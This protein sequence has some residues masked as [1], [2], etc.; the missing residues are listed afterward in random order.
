[1]AANLDTLKKYGLADAAETK[2]TQ[3]TNT[4]ELK[5]ALLG[6]PS[7]TSPS[8]VATPA[9]SVADAPRSALEVLSARIAEQERV[10]AERAERERYA[11]ATDNELDTRWGKAKDLAGWAVSGGNRLV[12][13]AAS[14]LPA[15]RGNSAL[16]LVDNRARELYAKPVRTPEEEAYLDQVP[17]YLTNASSN[18]ATYKTYRQL[19]EESTTDLA[20][21]K[22]IREA[23]E[24]SDAAKRGNPLRRKE[25]SEDFDESF[26]SV[27]KY[28]ENAGKAFK[29]GD[30]VEGAV[31]G[32]IGIAKL[33]VAG[34]GD[35]VENPMATWQYIAEQAAQLGVG[36]VKKVGKGLLAA[37][38]V[39]YG[40]RIYEER[41]NEYIAEHGKPPSQEEAFEMLAWAASAS[42]AEHL[43]ESTILSKGFGKFFG[44]AGKET[45]EA[46]AKT[47]TKEAP[48]SLRRRAAEG[49]KDIVTSI[50]S[51]AATEGYQTAVEEDLARLRDVQSWR[52]IFEGTMIGGAAAGGITTTGKT[53]QATVAAKERLKKAWEGAGI[54]AAENLQEDTPEQKRLAEEALTTGD[55]SKLLDTEGRTTYNPV[56][57]ADVLSKRARNTDLTEEQRADARNQLTELVSA[58]AAE[59]TRLESV[60][61][62]Q[63]KLAPLNES[64]AMLKEFIDQHPTEPERQAAAAEEI[65]TL[66]AEKLKLQEHADTYQ[67]T[68]KRKVGDAK[69]RATAVTAIQNQ[70][71]AS[72]R[73]KP[74]AVA[75]LAQKA[76]EVEDSPE[77]AEAVTQLVDMA[78][79]DPE[80]LS[81]LDDRTLRSLASSPA[82]SEE[83]REY[84]ET[85][86]E[87][88]AHA[89]ALN[90]MEGVHDNIL[91]GRPGFR[92]L[93]EYQA[94][95]GAALAKGDVK[96]V[97][98]LLYDLREFY[99]NHQAKKKS[100]EEAE[101]RLGTRTKGTI[102]IKREE[103]GSYAL[104]GKRP[105]KDNAGRARNGGIEVHASPK[106]REATAQRLENMDAELKAIAATGK[107]IAA[108]QQLASQQT[109]VTQPVK[110]SSPPPAPPAE[111]LQSILDST[112][113]N[114]RPTPKPKKAAQSV[115]EASPPVAP[116]APASPEVTTDESPKQETE[117]VTEPT[118]E[119]DSLPT[120]EEEEV[121]NPSTTPIATEPKEPQPTSTAQDAARVQ[122]QPEPE[123]AD[124]PD[125]VD[126]VPSVPVEENQESSLADEV[127]NEEEALLEGEQQTAEAGEKQTPAELGAEEQSWVPD[128]SK[129]DPT[130]F[131]GT[132][133]EYRE[134]DLISRYF[135]VSKGKATDASPK[136]LVAVKN[137]LSWIIGKDGLHLDRLQSVLAD[138]PTAEDL[139]ALG[140]FRMFMR[141]WYKPLSANLQ[142]DS[143]PRFYHKDLVQFLV[144]NGIPDNLIVAIGY[145]AF[146]WLGENSGG[147][148]INDDGA[149]NAIQGR[150]SDE[151][152][153]P[154]EK[155]LLKFSGTRRNAVATA[156]GKRIVQATGLKLIPGAPE[157]YMV[158]LELDL[159]GHALGLLQQAGF[160]EGHV[161]YS[162]FLERDKK[163]GNLLDKEG[164]AALVAELAAKSREL[165]STKNMEAESADKYAAKAN[166]TPHEFVR[167]RRQ[168]GKPANEVIEIATAHRESSGFL[169]KLFGAQAGLVFPSDEP[170][171]FEQERIKRSNR[172]IP[173]SL[174]EAATAASNREW[175]L[176]PVMQK[177]R[178]AFAPGALAFL[179]GNR[180]L[181]Y[182]HKYL[183]D[184]RDAANDGNQRDI[185]NLSLF[186]KLYSEAGRVFHFIPKIWSQQRSGLRENIINPQSSKYHRFNVSMP[187]WVTTF[188]PRDAASQNVRL[189][190]LAVAQGLGIKIEKGL[191]EQSIASLDA[192]MVKPQVK[193]ALG[194][195]KKIEGL[196]DNTQLSEEDQTLVLRVV[197]D[198][199]DL[200]IGGED[201][202]SLEALVQYARFEQ[203]R[204]DGVEFT[205]DIML[206]VDGTN[207]GP[208]LAEI[209]LGTVNPVLGQMFGFFTKN[210]NYTSTNAYK[211]VAGNH[212]LY[213][214]VAAL[215]NQ[216]LKTFKG[217]AAQ[218]A[219]D[220]QVF[221][222]NLMDANDAV[223]GK[224][225]TLVKQPVTSLIF[226]SG[227]RKTMKAMA[228]DVVEAFYERLQAIANQEGLSEADRVIQLKEAVAVM[229][230]MIPETVET[231]KR[232]IRVDRLP[233][234]STIQAAMETGLTPQQSWAFEFQYT[235]TVGQAINFA[236]D[237]AFGDFLERR[238]KLNMAAE[239]IWRR[240]NT[241]FQHLYRERLETLMRNGQIPS[242]EIQ[243]PGKPKGTTVR[244]PLEELSDTEM[245]VIRQT[246][247]PMAA[248]VHTPWSAH[249]ANIE[250][251]LDVEK[252]LFK[253]ATDLEV[254]YQQRVRFGKEV[255]HSESSKG[256][257]SF[258]LR[259]QKTVSAEPGVRTVIMLIHALDSAIASSVYK[260][261]DVLNLHDA[262]GSGLTQIT[263]G[264]TELNKQTYQWLTKYSVPL[265]I[266][267]ALNKSFT[268]GAK[269]AKEHKGLSEKLDYLSVGLGDDVTYLSD[270]LPQLR[271][272][273]LAME[274]NKLEYLLEVTHVNQYG[275]ET[276]VY[277]PT[278]EDRTAV[279]T[280][281]TRV[282]GLQANHSQAAKT[283]DAQEAR[284]DT[285][286]AQETVK[287]V[288]P[289]DSP[290]KDHWGVL[291]RPERS[292][293]GLV[294]LLESRGTIKASVLIPAIAAGLKESKSSA[295]QQAFYT[296]MLRALY[297]LVPAD[298]EVRYITPDTP[299]PAGAKARQGESAWFSN[300]TGDLYIG[301]KSTDYRDSSVTAEVLLHEL[302]HAAVGTLILKVQSY[303]RVPAQY[304]AAAAAIADLEN[305][306]EQA[307]EFIK[308]TPMATQFSEATKD[309]N[310]LIAWGTTN[311]AFQEQVLAKIQVVSPTLGKR[312]QESGFKKFINSLV[313]LLFGDKAKE[314]A[315]TGLAVLLANAGLLF[316]QTSVLNQKTPNTK[317]SKG[318][319]DMSHRQP[320]PMTFTS[321]EVF[322]ALGQGRSLAV[323]DPFHSAHLRKVLSR[324]VD[325]VYRGDTALKHAAERRAPTTPEDVLLK[326]VATGVLPFASQ[327]A[328]SLRL[329]NQ[330]AFV[331]E[332]VEMVVQSALKRSQPLYGEAQKLFLEARQKIS[333][334]DLPRGAWDTIFEPHGKD[335]LSGFIAAGLTY[336]PLVEKLS[337]IT[338][339]IDL[340]TL[341][342][343]PTMTKKVALL[344]EQVLAALG[345]LFTKTRPGQKYST[346]LQTIAEGLAGIEAR[347][348]S[349]LVRESSGA[350]QLLERAE[351]FSENISEKVREKIE[352][353]ARSKLLRDSRSALVRGA[354][355]G[356]STL[357]GGRAGMVM[358]YITTI[359]NE[360]W[361]DRLG[362]TASF[363]N[364]MRG[365][366]EGTAA[367][368]AL[369]VEAK[370]KEKMVLQTMVDTSKFIKG[371]FRTELTKEQSESVVEIV[372]SDLGA[373]LDGF[374]IAE[375]ERLVSDEAFLQAA[376]SKY[377]DMLDQVYGQQ[378]LSA[379]QQKE[380]ADFVVAQGKYLAYSMV[381]GVNGSP[382]LLLNAHA[383][384]GLAHTSH[385][386]T[387]KKADH[388]RVVAVLDPLISLYAVK[389]M[390]KPDRDIISEVMRNE[391]NR[392]DEQPNAIETIL[393]LSK[394]MQEDALRQ[395]FHNSPML[396][397]KGYTPDIV[398]PYIEVKA[399]TEKQGKT[400]VAAGY[401][402]KFGKPLDKDSADP[403]SENRHIYTVRG[404]G[405]NAAVSGAMGFISPK[406]RG[407]NVTDMVGYEQRNSVVGHIE[408]QKQAAV[409]AL[410]QR[411]RYWD[412]SKTI[413]DAQMAP[414][415]NESGEPVDYRY[416]MER[417]TKDNIL[418]RDNRVEQVLGHL[419]GQLV[420]KQETRALNNKAVQALKDQYEAEY[421][422]D[423]NAFVRVGP[424]SGDPVVLQ[425]YK[426]LPRET[427][428]EIRRVWGDA[429]MYVRNDIYDMMLGY[430]KFSLANSFS[431]LPGERNLAEKLFVSALTNLPII[432]TKR[433][434]KP[435]GKSA[436]LRVMQAENIW[437]ELVRL[438]KDIWVI[439]NLITLVN[440]ELSNL[441]LLVIWGINPVQY[442]KGRVAA[443]QAMTAYQKN[444]AQ[445]FELS[446][447]VSLGMLNGTALTDAEAEIAILDGALE[448]NQVHDLVQGGMYQ[449]LVED[450]S[451]E[452]DPYSYQS[453]LTEWVG[454]KTAG[455]PKGVKTV[456]KN[457]L[458][459]HDSLGYKLLN[460]ATIMSDFGARYV[461]HQ[462]LTSRRRNPMSREESLRT[463][464]AAF[465]HY[466][467]PTHQKLQY[468]NDMGIVP[469]TKYYL[470][471]Q[472]PL[473][474]AV[475]SNPGRALAMLFGGSYLDWMP[476]VL[477]SSL[478]NDPFPGSLSAG[479]F[480]LPGAIGEILPIKIG[481]SAW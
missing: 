444:R 43:G 37:T 173:Q 463:A 313:T 131:T 77:R 242:E 366:R 188:D 311:P 56:R 315:Q 225:R 399:A 418:E 301:V 215:M 235:V 203:A 377:E 408:R 109:P 380:R 169:D 69:L 314:S 372:R 226:G 470:R 201:F 447:L 181:P 422:S 356:I 400:L 40:H 92:G 364:E 25:L 355:A 329:T 455:V 177:V 282:I 209:Q 156:I 195:L 439:R 144:K 465:I 458:L 330:E 217:E 135:T 375:I 386:G 221:T 451:V 42:L 291:G 66:E 102:Y 318:D 387:V 417:D 390:R 60:D 48:K 153:S 362:F 223:T 163:T 75:E 54:R 12:A 237:E 172:D 94:Q 273:V 243:V 326:S 132:L 368:T 185:D 99:K 113:P 59:A 46:A 210:S 105:W 9:P 299:V 398:N 289:R 421:S 106:G 65:Q 180:E 401:T 137:F 74:E 89:N 429:G 232:T 258:G 87:Q 278:K 151:R 420:S 475:R 220:M 24:L 284:S 322:R 317:R 86:T 238:K 218:F 392:G 148:G 104:T 456:A 18:P 39:A 190:K 388:A 44:K 21:A 472:A 293:A 479:A 252:I 2:K 124:K 47:V 111:D 411:S 477:D 167:L 17:E 281:L 175:S 320:D 349:N 324:V 312:V 239:G 402:R 200:G 414:V 100:I 300:D 116:A 147:T 396:M 149:I 20:N 219:L 174:G 272:S 35:I 391:L 254:A 393:K 292:S 208:A 160:V 211:S 67:S 245:E 441:S 165:Q 361:K 337:Q 107:Q 446:K 424:D 216:A 407:W 283:T 395:E 55:V 176:R 342:D 157:N 348:K 72:E 247:K 298:L 270:F 22:A 8:P 229:N 183:K 11:F 416:L 413:K 15:M 275:F 371:L 68:H 480:E 96:V 410:F 350:S 179:A 381:T 269:L 469:F 445:H 31:Q 79:R 91:H 138:A 440:N 29:E 404:R 459:T 438:V 125:E 155:S 257:K 331:L 162:P 310:E 101:G 234:P 194:A 426:S 178:S 343:Q 134:L 286:P 296:Q 57:A 353:A 287:E 471:I 474:H 114:E 357:A 33:A 1:M 240:Y 244:V 193:A 352:T 3:L 58:Q 246:L 81:E 154:E 256:V 97:D 119:E 339:N 262:I 19:M 231:K 115:G 433:G 130:N 277:E 351:E 338:T 50:G 36:A 359:R 321:D 295:A 453:R 78:M 189:F 53:A 271:G 143:N 121:T 186:E 123:A 297:K 236:L 265:A 461:L 450:I 227:R 5:Q 394:Q 280:R 80:A 250:A 241:A 61:P 10:E 204:D 28:F 303:K 251:G 478:L 332:T 52:E 230:R 276:G 373:L 158:Q 213:E 161:I 360:F 442:I 274:R 452:N 468:L 133:E 84:F 73:I 263:A 316:E 367:G 327:T 448:Y 82:L 212:D 103:D 340:R 224:A 253:S 197:A 7:S 127:S 347:Y 431:K 425:R 255:P 117:T 120:E 294:R 30:S 110:E 358:D 464:R 437:Q 27:G 335:F 365:E 49:A 63:E 427:K 142:V 325:T 346:A 85:Y 14:F 267:N 199:D 345:R 389:Y 305:L 288:P 23:F 412:P 88:Q 382:A 266:Y 141:N 45:A 259:G 34:M 136:P 95:A 268:G 383:I 62:V 434:F 233:V 432:P 334:A 379:K 443:W 363:A 436:A 344:L 228:A 150:P 83:Q 476:T 260:N 403:S 466:D 112:P 374:T 384:A 205:T 467:V 146:T 406:S 222:G 279:Q 41:L 481:L 126:V 214:Y 457:V 129:A 385:K 248:V 328:L 341:R 170:G 76:Q 264:A 397:M 333:P 405:L 376:I 415:L 90:D 308:D 302:V 285:V 71:T 128:P 319:I 378:Q 108:A 202:H 304:K 26:E 290:E 196:P 370:Q 423:P 182:Q 462:H 207:N 261:H 98:A 122:A 139:S 428:Q 164:Q 198:L 306:L 323:T 409:N 38:N 4:A 430:H 449:T 473:V 168:N 187:S 419:A 16:S 64:I 454:E 32:G 435:M 93:K 152:V 191:E 184:S 118:A 307:R 206:E 309:V 369:L 140:T 171:K 70:L 166:L 460:K 6:G 192:A 145:G 354:A 13:E 159:G 51:E 249:D 336:Q